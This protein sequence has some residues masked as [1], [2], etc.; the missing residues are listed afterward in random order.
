[1]SWSRAGWVALYGVSM[2]AFVHTVLHPAEGSQGGSGHVSL[3]AVTSPFLG[4]AAFTVATWL[5]FRLRRR[6]AERG[7]ARTAAT[8]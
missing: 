6:R 8:I 7:L 3:A 5:F 2:F 4:F 1:M